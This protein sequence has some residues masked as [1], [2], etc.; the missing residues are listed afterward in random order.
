MSHGFKEVLV[1][2]AVGDMHISLK[3]KIFMTEY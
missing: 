1:Y 2:L 3:E